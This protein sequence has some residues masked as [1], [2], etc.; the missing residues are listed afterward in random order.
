MRDN[1]GP[2][3]GHQ[4]TKNANLTN[5]FKEFG[6]VEGNEINFLGNPSPKPTSGAKVFTSQFEKLKTLRS[7]KKWSTS[8]PEKVSTNIWKL[9]HLE[10]NPEVLEVKS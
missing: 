8:R 6:M 9:D 5:S 4:S 2:G 3:P 7:I 1:D 10:A